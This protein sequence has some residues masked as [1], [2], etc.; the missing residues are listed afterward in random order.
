M[1]KLGTKVVFVAD[2][3]EQGL[4][5]GDYGFI[6]AYD[7]NADNVFE[8]V[9]RAPKLNKHF[10][11]PG[12]DI[13]MEEVLIQREVD[14]LEKEALIDYALATR[15]EALFLRIM[16]GDM[17]PEQPEVGKDVQ[18]TEDFV[19]TVNLKAWI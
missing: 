4:P 12:D 1:L 19:K 13:E 18:S 5:I 9:V 16:N 6:I 8:Y 2:R 10:F 11:V 14:R 3:F 7:R 15:N 17:K